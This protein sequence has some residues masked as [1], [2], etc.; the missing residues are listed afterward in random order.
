TVDEFREVVATFDEA[1][2][3]WTLSTDFIVGFPT[4][5]DDDF[6]ASM[7]LLR[8]V[9]PEKINVTR[10]SKRPGTDAAS[11]K[12]LGGTLKKER[13]SAMTDLKM[14]VVGAA[15]E[16][17][18]GTTRRVLA[19]EPGRRDSVQAF[20]DAY[21]QIVVQNASEYGI[22]PG[23]FVDVTVTTHNTVYAM[24]EPVD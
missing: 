5:T 11:M 16:D 3:D 21:H 12:G 7:D 17:I 23:D 8:E 18:V 15:Y 6:Q 10:F 22:E 20:D 2:D 1:L 14:D 9:R 4:E 19:V 13:S 24:G